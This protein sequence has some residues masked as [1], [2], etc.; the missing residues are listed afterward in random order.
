MIRLMCLYSFSKLKKIKNTQP[1]NK[2]P[3]KPNLNGAPVM[4]RSILIIVTTPDRIRPS[5]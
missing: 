5:R 2:Q 4:F 1:Q 3:T